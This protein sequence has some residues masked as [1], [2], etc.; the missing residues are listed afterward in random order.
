M[1]ICSM[2]SVFIHNWFHLI[3]ILLIHSFI[4]SIHIVYSSMFSTYS[5]ISA[6]PLTL[7]ALSERA[8]SPKMINDEVINLAVLLMCSLFIICFHNNFTSLQFIHITIILLHQ[9]VFRTQNVRVFNTPVKN[10]STKMTWNSPFQALQA[11]NV[12]GFEYGIF[13][14]NNQ[15]SAHNNQDTGSLEYIDPDVSLNTLLNCSSLLYEHPSLP[16]PPINHNTDIPALDSLFSELNSDMNFDY[17]GAAAGAKSEPVNLD[18]I[19]RILLPQSN[20]RSS[21]SYKLSIASY[22]NHLIYPLHISLTSR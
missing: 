12:D 13:D 16:Q 6:V 19:E 10:G 1:Y 5:S 17:N 14:D 3:Y 21:K 11:A 18:D 4:C 2:V 20:R 9:R 22:P 7:V 15:Q 8:H